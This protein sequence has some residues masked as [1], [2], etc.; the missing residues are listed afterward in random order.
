MVRDLIEVHNAERALASA[1]VDSG[2]MPL[3]EYVLKYGHEILTKETY[4]VLPIIEGSKAS[5]P[6]D[7]NKRSRAYQRRG[8]TY[9]R[10]VKPF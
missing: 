7:T 8:G 2:Y 5:R 9:L 6:V 1:L 3:S 4:S 10:L